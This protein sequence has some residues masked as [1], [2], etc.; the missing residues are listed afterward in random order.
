MVF[1]DL[2]IIFYT[3][4]VYPHNCINVNINNKLPLY[5]RY[6]LSAEF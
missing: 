6:P 2:L 5:I 1:C 3:I 4:M